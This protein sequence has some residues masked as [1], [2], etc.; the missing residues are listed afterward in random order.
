MRGTVTGT[1]RDGISISRRDYGTATTITAASVVGG[2]RGIELAINANESRRWTNVA[3]TGTVTGQNGEGLRFYQSDSSRRSGITVA[4]ASA[5]GTTHGMY[6]RTG[7]TIAGAAN[8]YEG[9]ISMTVSGR[10]TGGA[11]GS[12]LKARLLEERVFKV[13]LNSGAVVGTGGEQYAV[14]T[15][16]GGRLNLT[17]NSRAT[18]SGAIK[19]STSK[20]SDEMTFNSGSRGTLS[21]VEGVDTLTIESGAMV[22]V[23]GSATS[24]NKVELKSGAALH[25]NGS[26]IG[27]FTVGGGNFAGGGALTVAADFSGATPNANKLYVNG[28]VTGTTTINVSAHRFGRHRRVP[29]GRCGQ[30]QHRERHQFHGR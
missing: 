23:S 27:S 30:Q 7:N 28:N 20:T 6:F 18:I 11:Q 14:S 21:K 4:A 5:T 25:L 13:T 9:S 16:G 19:V 2:E 22:S 8:R 17:V 3:W 24:V 26:T 15:S 29:G 12:A 10:V 1:R